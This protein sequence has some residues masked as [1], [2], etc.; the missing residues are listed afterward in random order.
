MSNTEEKC[1]QDVRWLYD[2]LEKIGKRPTEAQEE[3]F[4]ERVSI[5]MADG[6]MSEADARSVAFMGMFG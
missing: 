3:S 4:S 2:Q 1:D 5:I 6:K